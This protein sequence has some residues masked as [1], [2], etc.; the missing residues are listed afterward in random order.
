MSVR[1]SAFLSESEAEMVGETNVD[2]GREE[3]RKKDEA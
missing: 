2:E 3:A 1:I